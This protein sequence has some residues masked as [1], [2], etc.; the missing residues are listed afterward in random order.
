MSEAASRE[1]GVPGDAYLHFEYIPSQ[2]LSS[3]TQLFTA[4]DR[5]RPTGRL[6]LVCNVTIWRLYNVTDATVVIIMSS[7][8]FPRRAFPTLLRSTRGRL[9]GS[10]TRNFKPF[11]P[12]PHVLPAN[13]SPDRRIPHPWP[14]SSLAMPSTSSSTTPSINDQDSRQPGHQ[15]TLPLPR[16][17]AARFSNHLPRPHGDRSVWEL[18]DMPGEAKDGAAIDSDDEK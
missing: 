11:P 4:F 12:L 2:D 18:V 7:F 5:A 9:A 17:T 14:R 3:T 6:Y 15:Q 10:S 8:K 16:R 13:S 1:H